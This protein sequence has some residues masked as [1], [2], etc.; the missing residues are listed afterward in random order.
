MWNQRLP[1]K[2]S[3]L[4]WNRRLAAFNFFFPGRAEFSAAPAAGPGPGAARAGFGPGP[5]K[6][7]YRNSW[8]PPP[9]HLR[10]ARRLGLGPPRFFWSRPLIIQFTIFQ[11]AARVLAAAP[12]AWPPAFSELAFSGALLFFYLLGL[13]YCFSSKLQLG[14]FSDGC[15]ARLKKNL[16][17]FF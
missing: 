3:E 1:Y 4:L 10:A 9:G 14:L 11:M 2:T 5:K 13:I 17:T 8:P 15:H 7:P 16:T 12:S 6:N